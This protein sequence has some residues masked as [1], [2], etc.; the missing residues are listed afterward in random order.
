METTDRLKVLK[1]LK[2]LQCWETPGMFVGVAGCGIRAE[3]PPRRQRIQ[4]N[5]FVV[6]AISESTVHI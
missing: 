2:V 4:T 1:V 6:G 5:Y 3:N